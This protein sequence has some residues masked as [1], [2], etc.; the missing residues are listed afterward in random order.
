MDNAEFIVTNR[1]KTKIASV[2]H[3][4]TKNS[5]WNMILYLDDETGKILYPI[6]IKSTI[7]GLCISLD[8]NIS[9]SCL[10]PPSVSDD[11]VNNLENHLHSFC[12]VVKAARKLIKEEQQIIKKGHNNY[13]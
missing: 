5:K 2:I 1:H 9:S 4:Q 13:V 6:T 8:S 7:P 10:L 11:A 3:T 12:E